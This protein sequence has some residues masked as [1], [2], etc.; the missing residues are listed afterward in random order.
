MAIQIILS[1]PDQ[2]TTRVLETFTGLA[3]KPLKVAVNDGEFHGNWPFEYTSKDV[4]ETDKEF[5][6]RVIQETIKAL[7]K[8]YEFTEDKQRFDAQIDAVLRPSQNVPENI[9][10]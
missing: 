9:L 8:L 2:H 6:T 10:E 4:G 3:E 7:V 5:A 1:V